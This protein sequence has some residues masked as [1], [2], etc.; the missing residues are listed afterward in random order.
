MQKRDAIIIGIGDAIAIK[1]L[2]QIMVQMLIL[3]VIFKPVDDRLH[4]II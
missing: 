1:I 4:E 3:H 2:P